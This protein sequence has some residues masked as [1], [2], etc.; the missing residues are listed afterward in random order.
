MSQG[1]HGVETHDRLLTAATEVFAELGYRAATLREICRRAGAN[2][3]A[4]NYHFRDKESLYAEVV[5]DAVAVA[6]QGISSLVPD[7]GDS[8]ERKLRHFIR[9]FLDGLLGA[10]RPTQLLRLVA[11]EMIEPT[12]ALDLVVEMAARPA[13]DILR[14]I[15]AEL[16][17][18]AANPGRVRDCAASIISQCTAYQ[19]SKAM[20][21]RVDALDVHDPATIAH[22][23]DHIHHFSLGAIRA[24]AQSRLK[25][26]TRP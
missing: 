12:P 23:A 21:Q 9:A 18:P 14:A 7:P 3:A 15:I 16:L 6:G 4:V 1:P 11:H 10:D 17:G 8:P 25:R 19:H 20:V 2:V 13:D 5:R 26:S 24:M 22:L